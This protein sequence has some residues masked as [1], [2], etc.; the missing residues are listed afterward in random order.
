MTERDPEKAV[1]APATMI[2]EVRYDLPEMLREIEQER[3]DSSFAMET[4]EQVEIRK[5]FAS[6]NRRHARDKK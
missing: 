3:R 2:A 6:R 1:P 4:L 5:L